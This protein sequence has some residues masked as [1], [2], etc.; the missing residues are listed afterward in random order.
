MHKYVTCTITGTKKIAKKNTYSLHTQ[1]QYYLIFPIQKHKHKN[2]NHRFHLLQ[3][4]D[5]SDTYKTL[6]CETK[7]V[8]S[9]NGDAWIHEAFF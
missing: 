8:A 1:I 4:G 6:F 3:S 2:P 7:K 5:K 9:F